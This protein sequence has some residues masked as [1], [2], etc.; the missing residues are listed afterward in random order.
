MVD[1][2]KDNLGLALL[3]YD[4]EIKL[5][6]KIKMN[7]SYEFND[8]HMKR[9]MY[10]SIKNINAKKLNI[11]IM[12]N[13]KTLTFKYDYHVLKR[14]LANDEDDGYGF[15]VA[16]NKVSEFIKENTPNNQHSRYNEDF[17]FS[18][19]ISI[20]YG[21]KELYK[22]DDYIKSKKYKERER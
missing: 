5:L 4:D 12:Y 14:A 16:Y 17:E 9:K 15:G 2:N 6:N 7:Y 18:H 19:I 20:T 21:K 22:K 1:N 11:T 13:K 10:N 3:L 8:L